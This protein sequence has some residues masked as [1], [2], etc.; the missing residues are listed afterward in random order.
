MLGLLIGTNDGLLELIPGDA[1]KRRISGAITTIDYRDGVALAG[2]PAAGAWMHAGQ[3]WA[4][5][6]KDLTTPAPTEERPSVRAVRVGA[7]GAL[8]VGLEPAGL[9]VS[10]D[11]GVSWTAIE[12]IPALL[13][14]ER[15]L[16]TPA[17]ATAPYVA[18]IVFPDEGVVAGVSGAGAWGSRDQG[19]TWMRRSD[20]L[21]P[22]IRRLW[23]HPER[24][25]RLYAITDSGFYRTDDGG[26]SWVQS[27]RGLDRPRAWDVAVIPATPDRIILS[28]SRGAGG[29]EGALFRSINAGLTW[30]R[31]ALGDRDEFARAPL[32]TRVWDSEDTLFA[33]ADGI[34]WGSHDG[35]KSW[36][37]LAN[38]LPMSANVLVA[39]L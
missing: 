5:L 34:A 35:G 38:G 21:D 2:G 16:K 27:L 31:M 15:A 26:F 10:R 6:A 11:R 25:D 20:G 4:R 13:K 1:P 22:M 19:A 23:D 30:E 9:L 29:E 12:G 37:T 3:S 17:G 8:Y 28:V 36:M 39:A 24:G 32:V 33:L 7:D 18:G 14:H